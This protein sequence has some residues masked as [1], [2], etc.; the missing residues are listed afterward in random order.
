MDGSPSSKDGRAVILNHNGL[1]DEEGHDDVDSGSEDEESPPQLVFTDG[2]CSDSQLSQDS[3]ENSPYPCKRSEEVRTSSQD[4]ASNDLS[5]NRVR[6]TFLSR[7]VQVRSPF[8]G[9]GACN[10]V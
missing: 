8:Q 9:L 7:K 2:S 5:A 6:L 1:E 3:A 10:N 4:S